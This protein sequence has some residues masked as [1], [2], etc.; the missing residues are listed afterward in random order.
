LGRL[1]EDARRDFQAAGTLGTSQ[2]G[3]S[4]ARMGEAVRPPLGLLIVTDLLE[5]EL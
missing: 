4:I 5:I 1:W 2:T 3:Q